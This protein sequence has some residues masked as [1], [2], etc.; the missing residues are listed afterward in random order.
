M[1]RDDLN[2]SEWDDIIAHFNDPV[3]GLTVIEGKRIV[4]FL[5][6]ISEGIFFLHDLQELKY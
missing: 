3:A 6:S 5:W 4:M 2:S 1:D